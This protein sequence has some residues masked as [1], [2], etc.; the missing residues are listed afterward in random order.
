MNKRKRR[1]SKQDFMRLIFAVVVFFSLVATVLIF[2]YF[3]SPNEIDVIKLA[4]RGHWD[5]AMATIRNTKNNSCLVQSKVELLVLACVQGK[6]EVVKELI[7]DGIDPDE[8]NKAG[9]SP[10]I[11][12]VNAKQPEVVE[13]LVNVVRNIDQRD[14]YG[15]S[16]L[17]NASILVLS[18]RNKVY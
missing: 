7:E 4:R 5:L 13:F 12:A 15:R 2:L 16:A 3:K 1:I 8:R 14:P 18:P 17:H 9:V 6:L 11:A 10:L